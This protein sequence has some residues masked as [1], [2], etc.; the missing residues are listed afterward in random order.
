MR[1]RAACCASVDDATGATGRQ[2]FS[3]QLFPLIHTRRVPRANCNKGDQA[4][5]GGTSQN[6]SEIPRAGID[7]EI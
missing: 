1:A 4:V 6:L 7:E 3:G 5:I 2:I